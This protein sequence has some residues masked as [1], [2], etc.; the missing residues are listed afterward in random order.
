MEYYKNL[1]DIPP[2]QPVET[3]WK[4]P[5]KELQLCCPRL[6]TAYVWISL[7]DLK[8]SP[9]S[10]TSISPILPNDC[11]PQFPIESGI[12]LFFSRREP[13]WLKNW[14]LLRWKMNLILLSVAYC[15]AKCA[16]ATPNEHFWCSF[17]FLGAR[18]TPKV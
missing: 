5:T 13:L 2:W 10:L 9:C 8:C 12:P 6:S 17:L 4:N 1:S 7:D 14:R 15:Y 11:V 3:T 16:R 18:A